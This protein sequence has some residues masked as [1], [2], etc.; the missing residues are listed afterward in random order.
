M[1][2]LSR[3]RST[4]LFRRMNL[5]RLWSQYQQ[6]KT[7]KKLN[8]YCRTTTMTSKRKKTMRRKKKRATRLKVKMMKNI[9][10]GAT[11]RRTRCSMMPTRS[12]LLEMKPRSPLVD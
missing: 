9:L 12:K 11:L 7:R 2:R 1:C 4:T 6:G 3:N 8:R 5:S 10:L